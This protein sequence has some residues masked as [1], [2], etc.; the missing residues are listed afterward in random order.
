M[1][2]EIS[3]DGQWL[4]YQSNKSGQEEIYIRTFPNVTTT[5]LQVSTSGGT[6]PLWSPDGR[7]LFYVSMGT[8]MRVPLMK[9][10]STG[11]PG[12]PVKVLEGPYFYGAG[13]FS[14]LYRPRV[15]RR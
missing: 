6:Q 9:T 12:T 13:F 1:N 11:K 3:P 5:E 4:A 2:A 14:G 7:E 8:L 10:G 15:A